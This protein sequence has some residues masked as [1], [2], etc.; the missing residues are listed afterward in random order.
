[1][2]VPM[3]SSLSWRVNDCKFLAKRELPGTSKHWS[4]RAKTML[5]DTQS[6][7]PMEKISVTSEPEEENAVFEP[8]H[9][10]PI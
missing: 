9:R 6:E 7:P 2:V 8:K 1:M 10:M 4:T 5:H 3:I